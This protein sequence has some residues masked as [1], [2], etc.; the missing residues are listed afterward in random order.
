MSGFNKFSVEGQG[1]FIMSSFPKEKVT[2]LP[3]K[4][5]VTS[6]KV[7]PIEEVNKVT[8]ILNDMDNPVVHICRKDLDTFEGQSIG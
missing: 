6:E 7:T 1:K 2:L 8:T 5:V 3:N 4:K